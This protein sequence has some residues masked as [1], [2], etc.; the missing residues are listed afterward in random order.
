MKYFQKNKPVTFIAYSWPRI[1]PINGTHKDNK[2]T[3]EL[4]K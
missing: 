1:L 2:N 3:I 4:S